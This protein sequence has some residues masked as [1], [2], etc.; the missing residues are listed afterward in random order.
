MYS[1][2]NG[3][4][5]LLLGG[6]TTVLSGCMLYVPSGPAPK[7]ASWP[8]GG[9]EFTTPVPTALAPARPSVSA[10]TAAKMSQSEPEFRIHI[11]ADQ[12]MSLD[13]AES[14]R[15]ELPENNERGSPHTE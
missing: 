12:G 9:A 1:T 8:P 7:A 15:V 2:L 10:P 11:P 6:L 3:T 13:G 5:K 4:R 14:V